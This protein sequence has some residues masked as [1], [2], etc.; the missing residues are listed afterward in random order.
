[1]GFSTKEMHVALFD[2]K[3]KACNNNFSPLSEVSMA[4]LIS[5]VDYAIDL[6]AAKDITVIASFCSD[7]FLP[8]EKYLSLV[9]FLETHRDVK[10]IASTM[11]DSIVVVTDEGFIVTIRLVGWKKVVDV[12]DK[13]N[14]EVDNSFESVEDL[15]Q[16]VLAIE[17]CTPKR[18]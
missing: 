10:R 17:H 5:A 1:M 14:S 3:P 15:T 11:N 9:S 8:E 6:G 16:K 7:I 12:A 2:L 18:K 4:K 13:R